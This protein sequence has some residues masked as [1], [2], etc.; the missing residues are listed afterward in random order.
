M[1]PKQ[2]WEKGQEIVGAVNQFTH[3]S[4]CGAE[5]EST[6]RDVHPGPKGSNI[7]TL[8]SCPGVKCIFG[9]TYFELKEW[10]DH[11]A[12]VVA[13]QKDAYDTGFN[14]GCDYENGHEH[15]SFEAWRQLPMGVDGK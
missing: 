1:M 5:V 6:K 14:S 15:I 10:N 11:H 4:L 3:C 13:L 7:V 2:S 9:Y 8:Y 12:R